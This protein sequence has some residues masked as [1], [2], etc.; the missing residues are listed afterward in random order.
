M[1][2]QTEPDLHKPISFTDLGLDASVVE[3]VDK[4]GYSHPTEIQEHAIPPALAGK[5]VLGIAQTGTGKTASF[6]LPMISMLNRGRAKA[7]MPRSLVVAPTRELASQ[8]AQNFESYAVSSNLRMSLLIGGVSFKEQLVKIDRGVD[9]L[10][11]TPGR[12]LDHFDRGKLLLSGVKVLV[13][14]EADRMLDMGFIPDIERIFSLIPLPRQTLFF[15]ATMPSEIE[16]LINQNL[17][18]PVRVEVTRRATVSS[19]IDQLCLLFKPAH[20]SSTFREKQI[21]LR[22][23]IAEYGSD[24][25]KAIVFCNRKSD[26]EIL[27]KSM[28]KNRID[29]SALHGDLDQS[30]RTR[31]LDGFRNGEIRI[32]I[33]SDV[34]ARGLDVTD[35]SHVINFDVPSH[36]EDYVHR[37]G[38]TGRAGRTGK[39]ITFCIPGDKKH[40]DSIEK[41]IGRKIARENITNLTEESQEKV[42]RKRVAKSNERKEPP[43]SAGEPRKARRRNSSE[44]GK[45]VA[46]NSPLPPVEDNV[47]GMGDHI[48]EF[49]TRQI[50]SRSP[51]L[52]N[53]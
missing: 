36:S 27:S 14:D 35:V 23:Q 24:F 30:V 12:L 5:D 48:P 8:V 20:R 11:A 10:I 18:N 46:A 42:S 50:S 7:R 17:S 45:A 43:V 16:R 3:A 44:G 34:A 32:L 1:T 9:V 53:S 47:V 19:D 15:S 40:V 31:V 25:S 51:T 29:C 49:M 52:T 13:I 33:A 2:D 4:A 21:L 37:I 41:L 6:V 26:V 28:Q 22:R 38:R 39:A